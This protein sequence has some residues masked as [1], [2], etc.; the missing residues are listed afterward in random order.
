MFC[1]QKG[2][3]ILKN[4]YFVYNFIR[5]YRKD[6]GMTQQQL[7]DIVGVSKNII[8]DYELQYSQLSLLIAFCIADALGVKFTDVFR[9]SEVFSKREDTVRDFISIAKSFSDFHHPDQ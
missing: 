8:S 6:L 9:Y 5:A 1:F 4:H 7:A 3:N 2:V